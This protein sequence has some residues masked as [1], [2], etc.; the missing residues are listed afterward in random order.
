[1]LRK[2]YYVNMFTI[3]AV[4]LSFTTET[5]KPTSNARQAYKFIIIQTHQIAQ[6]VGIASGKPCRANT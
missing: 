6:A 3:L 2:V 1:M 5:K 4:K